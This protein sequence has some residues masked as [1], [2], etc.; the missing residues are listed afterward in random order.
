MSDPQVSPSVERRQADI[1]GITSSKWCLFL[2]VGLSVFT[3]VAVMAILF[4]QMYLKLPVDTKVIYIVIGV[5]APIITA[6]LGGA[7]LGVLTV[8]NGHQA[9]LIREIAGKKYAEGVIEGLKENPNTN[10]S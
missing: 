4:A 5:T 6:L 2:A 7:G 9:Q 1:A 3:V 10:I 8:L